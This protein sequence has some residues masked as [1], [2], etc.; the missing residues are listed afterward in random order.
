MSIIT[1]PSLKTISEKSK[2]LNVQ[3]MTKI[4]LQLF[5]N[6]YPY[7]CIRYILSFYIYVG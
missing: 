1:Y 6:I 4:Q 3:N 7:F 5:I 2:K